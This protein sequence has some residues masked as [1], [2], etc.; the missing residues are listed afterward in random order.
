MFELGGGDMVKDAMTLRVAA[1]NR[2]RKQKNFSGPLERDL[3]TMGWVSEPTKRAV[4]AVEDDTSAA[5]SK[6]GS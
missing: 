2:K 3:L 4:Q 1:S 5:G 6:S